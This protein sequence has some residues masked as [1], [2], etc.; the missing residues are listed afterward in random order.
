MKPAP[1]LLGITLL[2]AA[3]WFLLDPGPGQARP[4]PSIGIEAEAEGSAEPVELAEQDG[5][6]PGEEPGAS[7]DRQVVPSD[8]EPTGHAGTPAADELHILV[9]DENGKPIEGARSS[10]ERMRPTG[11]DGRTRIRNLDP[12]VEEL[13]FGAPRRRMVVA[14]TGA[15]GT[16][17]DPLVVVLPPG[18]H[19]TIQLRNWSSGSL[20]PLVFVSSK[21]RLFEDRVLPEALQKASLPRHLQE[22]S[23]DGWRTSSNTGVELGPDGEGALRI[24]CLADG[25]PL[26]VQLYGADARMAHEE[27]FLGPSGGQAMVREVW[28]PDAFGVR[29]R[30]MD[31]VG[32]AITGAR[33]QL[34]K[35]YQETDGDGHFL[36]EPLYP[37]HEAADLEIEARGY[38]SLR[39]GD[40]WLTSDEDLGEL[41]LHRTRTL[42]IEVREE[43]GQPAAGAFAIA[44]P[45][46]YETVRSKEIEPGQLVLRDVPTVPM[47][48]ELHHAS[49]TYG[50]EVPADSSSVS[51]TVPATGT[52][53][54][55]LPE[56]LARR[57]NGFMVA[58]LVPLGGN[59]DTVDIRL[60]HLRG[61]SMT[62]APVPPGVYTIELE[63]VPSPSLGDI[64]QQLPGRWQVKLEAGRTTSILLEN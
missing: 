25:V 6:V 5:P 4:G 33:V 41:V 40:L 53:E 14:R 57:R 42:D 20:P 45:D 1:A 48:I 39:R 11:P 60:D 27:S 31:D 15:G 12:A 16:E 29:G 2:V 18:N 49:R 50:K 30:V 58:H 55:H 44:H 21:E 38:A 13:L 47:R 17:S 3:G 62:A 35:W 22:G 64:E 59:G 56:L 26:T 37:V 63:E 8:E 52:L 19:L 36:F 54:L 43:T 7:V 32:A 9:I 51:F 61:M 34:G 24:G 46:G 28:L 10:L 23:P